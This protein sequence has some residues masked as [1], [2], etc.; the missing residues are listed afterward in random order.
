MKQ[1]KILNFDAADAYFLDKELV[2]MQE[3]AFATLTS[4]FNSEIL[5]PTYRMDDPGANYHE[6]VMHDTTGV[7]DFASNSDNTFPV[8]N[9]TRENF[10]RRYETMGTASLITF[11]D[12][13]ASRMALLNMAQDKVNAAV[14]RIRQAQNNMAFFGS[15]QH[16]IDGWLN[17][18]NVAKDPINGAAWNVGGV[19]KPADEILDDM[20]SC[21]DAS[22]IATDGAVRTNTLVMPIAQ[23][24]YI[25]STPRSAGSDTTILQYFLNNQPNITVYAANELKGAF[26]GGT[27]GMIAYEN[28]ASWFKNLVSIDFFARPTLNVE[29]G[30]KTIFETRLGGV[31]VIYPESQTFRYGI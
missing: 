12:T 19:V 17:A 20:N 24:A 15:P 22:M 13:R 26:P 11:Q 6:Y 10:L 5:I 8:V 14:L 9:V 4:P 25:K 31:I 29:N 23:Y 2:S 16:G 3:R 30:F 27:D 21:V 28:N 1:D 18:A 7:A